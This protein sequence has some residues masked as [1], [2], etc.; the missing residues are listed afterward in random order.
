MTD[1]ILLRRLKAQEPEALEAM[2]HQY[3]NLLYTIIYNIIRNS[4]S[5]ADVEELISD[6]FF[7]VWSHAEGI[8]PGNLKAYLCITARN[9]AKTFLR[10]RRPLVMDIDEID[11]P[12][13]AATPEDTAMAQELQRCVKKA[14]GKMRPSDR[15]IFLRYYYYLQSSCEIAEQMHIPASTVRTRL[16]RGRKT[17]KKHLSKEV[18]F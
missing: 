7:S 9:K 2:M 17:L 11:L 12:D 6:T 14:I 8:A 4:G 10:S 1:E 16:A 18:L 13:S 3:S 5:P 15:E